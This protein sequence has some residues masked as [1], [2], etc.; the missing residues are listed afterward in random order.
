MKVWIFLICILLY[1]SSTWGCQGATGSIANYFNITPCCKIVAWRHRPSHMVWRHSVKI[2]VAWRHQTARGIS[3]ARGYCGFFKLLTG[4]FSLR[5]FQDEI[6]G[7]NLVRNNARSDKHFVL[8]CNFSIIFPR[9]FEILQ[10]SFRHSQCP[11]SWYQTFKEMSAIQA[12]IILVNMVAFFW[13][14][15]IEYSGTNL[16]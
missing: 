12:G 15:T 9:C 13:I 8:L 1:S 7:L 16:L 5:W 10:Y 14:H 11:M 2:K 6:S 4:F 3:A